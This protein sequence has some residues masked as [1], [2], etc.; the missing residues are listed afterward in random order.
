MTPA[1]LASFGE[2]SFK[3]ALIVVV[4]VLWKSRAALEARYMAFVEKY[5]QG[6]ETSTREVESLKRAVYERVIP[7]LERLS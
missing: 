7:A 6:L 1:D 5:A 2:L 3:A 4:V